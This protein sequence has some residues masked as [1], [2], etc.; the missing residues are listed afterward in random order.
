MGVGGGG[1]CRGYLPDCHVDLHANIL[2]WRFRHLNIVGC[3]LKRRP[4]KG[5]FGLIVK[6]PLGEQIERRVLRNVF[7]PKRS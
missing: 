3:L 7:G 2:S 4:T 1:G 6:R 5:G